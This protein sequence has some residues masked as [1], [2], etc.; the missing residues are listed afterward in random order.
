MYIV[1][2][3]L[4]KVYKALI[5]LVVSGG[6]LH[7]PSDVYVRTFLCPFYTL[8][9]LLHKS[10]W[11]IKLVPGP[12]A[13]S[14]SEITNPNIVHRNLSVSNLCQALCVLEI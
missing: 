9:K 2:V 1:G 14:S 11:V 4:V 10:S 3:G 8:I 5:R 12:E 7:P 13:K 6:T